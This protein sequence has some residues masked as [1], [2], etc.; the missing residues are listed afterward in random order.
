VAA[1]AAA[2]SALGAVLV[3]VTL[4]GGFA[5]TRLHA[6]YR[7][8]LR[9]LRESERRLDTREPGHTD[10]RLDMEL[11]SLAEARDATRDSRWRESAV[12]MSLLCIAAVALGIW[13]LTEDVR[14]IDSVA[15][16]VLIFAAV[17]VTILL[18]LDGL[19]IRAALAATV[20]RSPLWAVLRLES[21][22]TDT[23][24]A[25]V[26][27][28]KAH[29]AWLRTLAA[30]YPLAGP[31][32]RWRLRRHLRASRR[33]DAAAD[34]LEK[35]SATGTVLRDLTAAG[36][37]PPA[38]Y[39]E[40]LRG[41]L[42]LV[43]RVSSM[44]GGALPR[45]DDEEEWDAALDDL[46]RAVELDRPRHV[47]WLSALAACAELRDDPVARE[48]A[49]RWTL[50]MAALRQADPPGPVRP[51]PTGIAP[52]RFDPLP[53]AAVVE[54]RRSATWESALRRARET[55]AH[56]RL[57]AWVIV[58]WAYALVLDRPATPEVDAAIAPAVDA[59]VE[60]MRGLP[61]RE[62]DPY[63]GLVRA[64]LSDLG[65][66]GLQMARLVPPRVAVPAPVPAGAAAPAAP[67]GP[68]PPA[69]PTPPSPR[70]HD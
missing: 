33:R 2:L 34:R 28:R 49:A 40:G 1:N 54:P 8:A 63:L 26:R 58:R 19:R 60:I 15:V 56:P 39:V 65:A 62:V 29:R 36:V 50:E 61:E 13:I 45:L 64:G 52:D 3:I 27:L 12:L 46:N 11:R 31:I 44:D 20:Q 70:S 18:V 68:A 23:Y 67:A 57:L 53:D 41:L 43:A 10:S 32:G 17:L 48:S 21:L 24:R 6:A 51:G 35:W 47:R 5:S 55:G 16:L 30:G 9:D 4:L 66:S 22:L 42:P 38:G 7:D 14:P 37:R 25:T 59:A 69:A